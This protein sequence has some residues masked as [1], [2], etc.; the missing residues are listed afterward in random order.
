MKNFEILH[1]ETN[2]L[3]AVSNKFINQAI[4]QVLYRWSKSTQIHLDAS[5]WGIGYQTELCAK[6]LSYSS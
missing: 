4:S 5:S 6:N 1:C 2:S 3:I